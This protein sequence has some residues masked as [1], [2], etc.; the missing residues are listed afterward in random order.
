[1][2]NMETTMV[3]MIVMAMMNPTMAKTVV[4]SRPATRNLS[5][6]MSSAFTHLNT[7]VIES[8][9]IFWFVFYQSSWVCKLRQEL[10]TTPCHHRPATQLVESSLSPRLQYHNSCSE[11]L[12]YHQCNIRVT[13]ATDTT[14]VTNKQTNIAVEVPRNIR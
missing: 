11:S 9:N 1:M 13:H 10:L 12:T 3:N 7:R 14:H 5:R 2:N 6:S 8:K 4:K